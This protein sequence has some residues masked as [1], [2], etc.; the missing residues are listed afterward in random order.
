L[1][2]VDV[3]LSN[4]LDDV[5]E[6]FVPDAMR[7]ELVEA[8]HLARYWWSTG[9]AKG[10]RVLDA[11]CGLGYGTNLLAAAGA[12]E[13][14]GVDIAEAV[15]EAAAGRA[16]EGARFLS[17]GIHDLPFEDGSFDLIVCFEVIEHVDRAPQAIAELTRA[18][19]P[20]GVLAVSSPN[21][22]VYVPGNPHHVHEFSAE[23]LRTVLAG[24]FPH[25]E[26]RQQHN[27]IVS[28]VLEGG[29]GAC[30]PLQP[31]PAAEIAQ[32]VAA[33]EDAAPYTIAI[34]SRQPLPSIPVRM[35]A[36]GLAEV[37]RWLE[38]YQQ[39]HDLLV[40]QKAYF[41]EMRATGAELGELHAQLRKSE[42]E[43][44]RVVDPSAVAGQI[45][46]ADLAERVARAECVMQEMISS[47][48]WRLT[49]PLRRAKRLLG[50]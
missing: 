45:G 39:Q 31:I 7:G 26:V 27:L 3:D 50:R 1:P 2:D 42:E 47:P 48:S 36:T 12:V 16:A 40:A 43:I 11:G 6:R 30:V 20:D 29:P 46:R 5:P 22:E 25:V 8:E 13:A 19:S 49:A 18:L 41:E 34:G 38:L 15:V 21:P 4:R 37:R 35:V 33:T 17:A 14:V 28:S 24:H 23:E 9:F 10:R 44:A 32:V